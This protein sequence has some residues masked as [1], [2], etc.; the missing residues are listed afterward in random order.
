VKPG[1]QVKYSLSPR[2]IETVGSFRPIHSL[3]EYSLSEYSASLESGVYTA[4]EEENEEGENLTVTSA[5]VV[6]EP[7]TWILLGTGLAGLAYCRRKKS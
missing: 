6:P 4:N 7:S 1:K 3:S 2:F 5:A